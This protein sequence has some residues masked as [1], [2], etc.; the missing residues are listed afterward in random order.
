V[1]LLARLFRRKPVRQVLSFRGNGSISVPVADIINSPKV[2]A[3]VRAVRE[4]YERNLD[5]STQERTP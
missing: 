4:W 1:S 2:Q 3:Q 5:A